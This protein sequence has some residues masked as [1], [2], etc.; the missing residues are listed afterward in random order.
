MRAAVVIPA[1][2][3][4]G[5]LPGLLADLDRAASVLDGA[6]LQ[7][8]VVVDNGSIDGTGDVA[9]AA[10]AT[11]I[12]E[13]RPGYGAACLAGLAHLRRSPPEVV[14]FLDGDRSDDPADLPAVLSPIVHGDADLVIGSRAL[15]EREPGSLTPAQ[16]FG[17]A[18]AATMIRLLFGARVTDL[19]PFRAARW[20]SLERLGMRDPDYGWTVEMQTRALRAGIRCRE[21]P[22][23]YRRRR[24]GRSKV[25]GTLRGALGAGTKIL[26]TI[27]RVRLGG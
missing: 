8:V 26:W 27:V 7:E 2:N 17:N 24:S 25:A 13:P 12:R 15:G 11:V 19:G 16:A 10:G 1:R 3:E 14:I 18:L 9:R 6:L 5:A 4:A 21:V 23:R 22:V 20:T